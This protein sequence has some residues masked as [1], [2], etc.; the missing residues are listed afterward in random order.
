[1]LSKKIIL[2]VGLLS[3]FFEN[4][5]GAMNREQIE[6]KLGK[7]VNSFVLQV[8]F[9]VTDHWFYTTELSKIL[10]V[11]EG[12]V[13]EICRRVPFFGASLVPSILTI[14]SPVIDNRFEDFVENVG[15]FSQRKLRE[16]IQDTLIL[17]GGS[18]KA[19]SMSSLLYY[20]QDALQTKIDLIE[21]QITFDFRYDQESFYSM[22]KSVALVA[23][24][25]AFI[26]V[27]NRYITCDDQKI[28]SKVSH[29]EGLHALAS[30]SLIPISYT[31]LKNSYK[32]FTKDP[33]ARNQY[34]HE[35]K[36]LL[37]F[38]QNLNFQLQTDGCIVF[39]LDN[40]NVATVQEH[41]MWPFSPV[42]TL[43]FS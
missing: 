30:L 42:Q 28:G 29:L 39:T 41:D 32:V 2:T 1:M 3:C 13:I 15:K 40:G 34:L 36:D 24:L 16:A 35:Y 17:T 18:S 12:P 9:H 20:L 31:V 4:I 23:S 26:S 19:Y 22:Q 37:D 25:I 11:G 10:L 27:A 38:V 14:I 5:Q 6:N 33:N 7:P 8:D 43:K 21:N